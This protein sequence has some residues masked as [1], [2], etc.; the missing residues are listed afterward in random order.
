MPDADDTRPDASAPH[1]TTSATAPDGVLQPV[2][3]RRDALE[4]AATSLESSLAEPSHTAAWRDGVRVA[5]GRTQEVLESHIEATSGEQGLPR[6]VVEVAPRLA[7]PAERLS[8]EHAD[9]VARQRVVTAMADDEHISPEAL[10]DAAADLS[11]LLLRHVK[12]AQDLL[13][14]A[15]EDEIGG[16]D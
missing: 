15:L 6:S 3:A 4:K 11:A 7:G 8:G 9:L 14:D 5:L 12:N 2:R 1:G 13:V 16:G 10:R